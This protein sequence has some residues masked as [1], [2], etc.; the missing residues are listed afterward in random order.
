[1]EGVFVGIDVSGEFL[2]VAINPGSK[3]FRVGNNPAGI[4]SLR[5]RLSDL[6]P[7]LVV[8]EATGRLEEAATAELRAAGIPIHVANPRHVRDFARAT[9]RL[10]KTDKLDAEVI[11]FFAKAVRPDPQES[12]DAETQALDELVTRR[13]Q[14]VEMLA[15]EKTRQS[16][17]PGRVA[18]RIER[19]IEWLE[20]ELKTLDPGTETADPADAA[21]APKGRAAAKRSW[22]GARAL[23]HLSG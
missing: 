15:A 10:A 17:A 5:A 1:M 8:L 14:V 7:D 18:G 3:S 12:A 21:P 13:R 2:D 16:R 22:G 11:A 20:E 23:Q 19:H 6:G 9:G 4:A